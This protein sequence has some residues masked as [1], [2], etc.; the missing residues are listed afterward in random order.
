M[1]AGLS[2]DDASP[3]LQSCGFADLGQSNEQAELA[4]LTK[5]THL[6]GCRLAVCLD[7]SRFNLSQVEAPAV[8]DGE[9]LQALT[10]KVKDLI[11]Y[12]L[13]ELVLD[14]VDI[15]PTKSAAEMVY[16]VASRRS[17]IQQIV[18]CTQGGEGILE[19]I[20]IPALALQNI[21]AR[22]PFADE[23][24]AFLNLARRDSQLILGRAEKLYLS[25]G[26]DV[27][28][29]ELQEALRS[30]EHAPS[31]ALFERLLLD[32]QRSLDYYD[33]FFADPP[34]Q[35][36]LVSA[37]DTAFDE[38]IDHLSRNLAIAVRPL[39]LDDLVTVSDSLSIEAE[40]SGELMLAVGA[41]LW[42]EDLAS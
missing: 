27:Q 9:R 22:L 8:A 35:H 6:R 21:S 38:L 36:L 14:Y 16:T 41:A 5:R 24:V 1:H 23:G 28:S 13:D 40:F 12:P 10:W 2:S 7:R 4:A 30:S 17:D 18:D 26:V 31:N 32:V 19:R 33:S 20:D 42:Q 3:V 11:D 34:I 29:S 15:P 37:V 25:R 39:R